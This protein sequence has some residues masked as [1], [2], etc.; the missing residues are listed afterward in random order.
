MYVDEYLC[1]FHYQNIQVKAGAFKDK[2]EGPEKLIMVILFDEKRGNL[3]KGP[4]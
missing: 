4:R 3:R 2:L 1:L